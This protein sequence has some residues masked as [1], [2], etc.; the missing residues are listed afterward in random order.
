MNLLIIH[1]PVSGKKRLFELRTQI[2]QFLDT[3][4]VSATWIN[5]QQDI[6]LDLKDELTER[7]YDAVIAIGGDG[8]VGEV[9]SEVI[10]SGVSVPVGIVPNGSANL[11]AHALTLP[12]RSPMHAF[13]AAI[14]ALEEQNTL[15]LDAMQTNG[16]TDRYGFV[17]AGVGYDAF[18]IKETNRS[19]KRFLGFW[20]YIVRFLQSFMSFD[21][22]EY[23]LVVDGQ[24]HTV[25]AKSIMII[26]I[27]AFLGIPFQKEMSPHDGQLSV[28][29]LNPSR[30]GL[31][32][33]LE[34][35]LRSLLGVSHRNCRSFQFFSGKHISISRVDQQIMLM[36]VDGE[37]VSQ[38]CCAVQV[39][40][41]AVSVLRA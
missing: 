39:L 5:T 35:V 9:L 31:F 14:D 18:L 1:N 2:E 8:T 26:N 23:V 22:R 30:Y 15:L 36:Q 20:A 4:Q 21:S 17:A 6:P 28:A 32:R 13:R 19:L 11:L 38:D 10:E 27:L 16:A 25:H 40:P 12:I 33:M 7:S 24:T 29:V 41:G 37:W 34:F 3:K